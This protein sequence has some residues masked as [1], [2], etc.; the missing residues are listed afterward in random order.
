MAATAY[1]CAAAAGTI[2]QNEHQNSA[3]TR[4]T[5]EEAKAFMQ[6]PL[7]FHSSKR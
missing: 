3:I 4:R 1:D 5:L 7:F 2:R 6:I